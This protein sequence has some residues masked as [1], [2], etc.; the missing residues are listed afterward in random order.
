MNLI[1]QI[2]TWAVL[3]VGYSGSFLKC[4]RENLKQMDQRT[5]ELIT[6]H[7]ALHPRNEC[8]QDYICQGKG[9]EKDLLAMKSALTHRYNNS[10]FT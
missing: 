7:K 9:E 5:R 4:T 3:L 6:M 8:W 1:K 10:R 2:N